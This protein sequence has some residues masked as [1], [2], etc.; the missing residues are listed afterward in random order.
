MA[1]DI[2]S[3]ATLL[4]V[5]SQV[6]VINPFWLGF[7][8]QQINFE[9]EEI[10]W[11]KV[12]KDY[13]RLAPLVVPNVQGRMMKR[14]GFSSV[15]FRPAYVKPKDYVDPSQLF[16]RQAGE[17]FGT[18]TG[19]VGPSSLESRRRAA[20]AEI[21]ASHRRL[22]VNRNEWLAAK[23]LI[24]GQVVIK[25][26]DYPETLVDF[27]RHSSLTTTL[28][29]A[30]MWSDPAADPLAD[31][32]NAKMN[33]NL[34]S[35][36]KIT[37]IVFGSLAWA[38]FNQRVD[39]KELQDKNYGG[40]SADIQRIYDGYEGQEYMGMMQ[41]SQGGG[42][43]ELWVDT[44]KYVDE[45]DQEQYF[46]PQNAVVGASTVDGVRCFGAIRDLESLRAV[47]FFQKMWRN[48]DPSVEYIL[49]QSA[50]LMV[51]KKPNASFKIIVGPAA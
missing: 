2:Y 9:T 29:G 38:W 7:F 47:E 5:A 51:P 46:L 49:T 25:G 35:G 34:R 48:E 31:L 30:A 11:D 36:A 28:T 3:T 10:F 14:G 6:K 41:G 37:R 18:T 17:G 4:A 15:S 23:A 22:L 26:E 43:M 32:R 8:P 21:V 12:D 44:S 13:R 27:G 1:G 20:I 42:R 50:P 45:N 40:I 19:T 33:A 39:L 16:V 24:D